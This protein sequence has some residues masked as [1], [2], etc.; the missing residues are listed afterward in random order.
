[1][2]KAKQYLVREEYMGQV[3]FTS[4][5]IHEYN[6]KPNHMEKTNGNLQSNRDRESII[7]S[8]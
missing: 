5:I 7:H 8:G 3:W 4:I 2:G 6:L 1:M